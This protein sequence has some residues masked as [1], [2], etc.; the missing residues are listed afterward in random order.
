MLHLNLRAKLALIGSGKGISP[1]P[2]HR[3]VRE[4]LPSYGSCACCTTTNIQNH[5]LPVIN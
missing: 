5:P 3:T 4:S 2:S 1:L